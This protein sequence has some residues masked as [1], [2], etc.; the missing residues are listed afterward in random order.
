MVSTENA[1][2]S[3]TIDGKKFSCRKDA[4]ILEAAT[5]SGIYV[6]YLCYH[7]GMKPFGACRMCVVEVEGTRG[8]VA[9]CTIPVR[10]DMVINT[11]SESV[12][13]TRQGIL[14]LQLAEHPQGCLT[15]HRVELCGP[16]D[17]CLRHVSVNDRCVTCPK[18]E[19][20]E[21]KDTVRFHGMEMDSPLKYE[22]RDLPVDNKD[23]FYDRDY[24][25]CIVCG[26]CVRVCD[27]VRGDNAITFIDRA[28][29]A[30]VGTSQGTSLLES[31]CEFC[32]ACLDVCPVGALTETEHKWD[33]PQKVIRTTCSQCPVGCQ[34]NL[35]VNGYSKVVRAVGELT[36]PS[37]KGQLCYKGKFGNDFVN[38]A[39]RV[40]YPMIRENGDLRRVTW[41]VA[42]KHISEK[43]KSFKEK[44]IGLLASSSLTNEEYYSI[45]KFS[46]KILKSNNV[47]K[48]GINELNS[49]NLLLNSLG[50]VGASN[51]LMAI[52]KSEVILVFNANLTE[53]QNVVGVP[54]KR[55]V[56]NG[57]KLVV[58]DPREVELSRY[59]SLWL[60]PTPGTELQLLSLLIQGLLDSNSVELK[61]LKKHKGF[62]DLEKSIKALNLNDIDSSFRMKEFPKIGVSQ[63]IINDVVDLLTSTNSISVVYGLDNI[64]SKLSQSCVNSITSLFVLAGGLNQGGIYPLLNGANEQGASDLGISPNFLPGYYD[65]SKDEE[66]RYFA[67]KWK[68]ELPDWNGENFVN[69]I[70][71]GELTDDIA[72]LVFGDHTDTD[73]LSNKKLANIGFLV[74]QTL[75]CDEFAENADVILPAAA[76][77]EKDG[78]FTNLERRVQ[79]VRS[80]S[81]VINGESKSSWEFLVELS[82][83]M[84]AKGFEYNSS[85]E[86]LTEISQI[87]PIYEGIT[88]DTLEKSGKTVNRPPLDN[89]LPT[90]VL[91]SDIE[92]PGIIWNL[93]KLTH[94]EKFKLSLIQNEVFE[95][96]GITKFPY[97]LIPG[98]VLLDTKQDVQITTNGINRIVREQYFKMNSKDAER[99]K[100]KQNDKIAV[101]FAKNNQSSLEGLLL[102]DD[103]VPNGFVITTN[104]FGE[105]ATMLDQS[106]DPLIMSKVPKLSIDNINVNH[107]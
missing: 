28:G 24:N 107:I 62:N 11:V 22:Y 48:Y 25:L 52:E 32:G 101:S 77:T 83:V 4:T 14:E 70:Q 44:K 90:Q 50:F 30:L 91:Y 95:Y 65:V 78:T 34:V 7:P 6:P 16:Q 53:A 75:Y 99:T 10:P 84:N 73:Q 81:N 74:Y 41:P 64:D 71:S 80:I 93:D 15:C 100:L 42:L 49:E 26:R 8:Q 66:R 105:M 58:I 23:P 21:L 33:K 59:S 5:E 92:Y 35:E 17:V 86:I 57:A 104:L 98:R 88:W 60:N 69:K 47:N 43:L 55:A 72:L 68:S 40:K 85:R 29:Q 82:K 18:N 39:N 67:N 12:E 102:I 37:N 3:I 2:I 89:P 96:K 46:R 79:Q 9:S 87:V 54:I 20:C 106:E 63:D 61:E 31:G 19:R 103:S 36:G 56:K 76:F 97:F 27:E 94:L 38:D 51:D 13:K 1:N 45:Q